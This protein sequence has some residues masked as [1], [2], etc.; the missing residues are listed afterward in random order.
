LR[1]F[2]QAE[3]ELC[4]ESESDASAA[5]IERC[6]E[7]LLAAFRRLLPKLPLAE[8]QMEELLKSCVPLGALTDIIGYALSL[9]LAVKRELLGE[10]DAHRRAR[11]LLAE[12][13]GL[14]PGEVSRPRALLEYP[15]RFSEN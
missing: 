11:R 6:R 12:L 10:R 3:V 13:A 4:E 15:P 9:D 1:A 5:E 8:D 2:R 14:S 7:E